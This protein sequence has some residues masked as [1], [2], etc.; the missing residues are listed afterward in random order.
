MSRLRFFDLHCD[1]LTELYYGN[2]SFLEN[3]LHISLKKIEKYERYAQVF[4]IFT[5]SSLS[6]EDGYLAFLKV[7]D[8]FRQLTEQYSDWILPSENYVDLSLAWENGKAAAF[9]AVE[10]ARILAGR[11]ERLREIYERGVRFLT[12]LWTGET[13]IGGSWNTSVG[14]TDFGKETVRECFRLGI[15]PDV[16][17][18][19][20]ASTDD[21]VSIAKEYKR[22]IVA[23]HSDSY[24]V[25]Q[26]GRNLSDEHFESIR[27]LGG[28][29]G[30]NL[31]KHHLSDDR[32]DPADAET[33]F[34]HIA[35]YLSIGGEDIVS[36]G[37]DFDGAEFPDIFKDLTSVAILAEIM[38]RHNYS[39]R[40]VH[41]IFSQNAEAFIRRTL[42]AQQRDASFT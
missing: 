24:S 7:S 25:Y 5:H 37:C 6:D 40:L 10:D 18:A 33:V 22:P 15:V 36:F 4:A 28:L 31:Y 9:L 29:V 1:T 12:L 30:I 32:A 23:T 42:P 39:E 41:K 2:R 38:L 27:C 35:H 3:D 13:C 11:I 8:F 20:L 19:S 34:R 21:I 14:L 17:H 26:H 16:S